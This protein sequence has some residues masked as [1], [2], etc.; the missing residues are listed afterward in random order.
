MKFLTTILATLFLTSCATFDAGKTADRIQDATKKVSSICH[1]AQN[2]SEAGI[3]VP[4][5]EK[6]E[7]FLPYLK[8]EEIKAIIDVL[9][10]VE[11]YGK[12]TIDLTHCAV[13]SNW[14]PALKHLRELADK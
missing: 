8:S 7:Q 5:V 2:I 13:D 3:P 12:N 11:S 6:C 4:E 1:A 9:N 10:C 14:R